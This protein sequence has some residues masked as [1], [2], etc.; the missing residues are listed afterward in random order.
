[1]WW[2]RSVVVSPGPSGPPGL[3][4][5]S[6]SFRSRWWAL[7]LDRLSLDR[8]GSIQAIGG[9]VLGLIALFSSNDHITLARH[10]IHLQQQWGIPCI[11]ASV[12]TSGCRS[13]RLL[14]RRSL[15]EEKQLLNWRRN[16]DDEQRKMQHEQ[17]M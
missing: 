7:A 17:R 6:P 3:Q 5:S 10:T 14:R 1:M 8:L 2:H 4:S 12:A 15:L 11:A 13:R 9:F 16:P